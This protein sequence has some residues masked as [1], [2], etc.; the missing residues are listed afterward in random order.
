M[1]VFIFQSDDD[2]PV[3]LSL[4]DKLSIALFKNDNVFLG[5]LTTK[6]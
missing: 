4:F 3:P 6:K 1:N 2:M 5:N